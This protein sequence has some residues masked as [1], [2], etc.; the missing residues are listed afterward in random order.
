VHVLQGTY[1]VPSTDG[2]VPKGKLYC[3]VVNLLT[4]LKKCGG[5]VKKVKAAVETFADV[6][7]PSGILNTL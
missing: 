1:F 5:E 3:R 2:A 4:K 7:F 6:E